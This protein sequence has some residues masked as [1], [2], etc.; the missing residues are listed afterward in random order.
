MRLLLLV[1][2]LALVA[3]T[4]TGTARL[5]PSKSLYSPTG[6]VYA[7]GPGSTEGYLYVTSSNF[8]SRYD[9]G[10]LTAINLSKLTSL[11]AFGTLRPAGDENQIA[12]IFD[13]GL[14][15]DAQV[16]VTS[17]AG[18]M[19]G[20][21]LGSSLRLFTP[22]R[23]ENNFLHVVDAVGDTLSCHFPGPSAHDCSANEPSTT[24]LLNVGEGKPRAPQPFGVGLWQSPTDPSQSEL[25]V[26]SL[27]GADSPVGS[28]KDIET[29]TVRLDPQNPTT[30]PA[31]FI[32]ADN[33]IN[34]TNGATNS[35]AVGTRYAYLTGRFLSPRGY[36][37]RLVDRRGLV[38]I[39]NPSLEAIFSAGETRGI[40]LD[41]D[42]QG[43]DRRLYMA[44]RSPDTLLVVDVL[45]PES[46]TPAIT[47][48]HAVPL[49]VGA[50]EVKLIKRPGVGRGNLVAIASDVSGV[51]SIYDDEIGQLVA[52]VSNVGAQ[53]FGIDVQMENGGTG[54]RLFVTTFDDGRVEVLDMPSLDAPQDVY[55]VA[56]LGLPQFCLFDLTN[57]ACSQ[58]SP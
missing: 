36:L 38:P 33:F 23:A 24:A 26:T 5:P 35:V 45:N 7:P 50:T 32:T 17:F 8:D 46:D 54:A 31:A 42:A 9:Y 53:P 16:L 58:V 11:P 56:R 13:L 57:P 20:L 22:S 29:F 14:G 48:V 25:W 3:C 44:T 15:E 2:T 6:I 12:H 49:P 21:P 47:L 43:R 34:L 41:T 10:S 52:Q 28:N 1:V 55:V 39:I 40:A 37:L 51:L 30:D 19:V 18:E 27:I 4:P